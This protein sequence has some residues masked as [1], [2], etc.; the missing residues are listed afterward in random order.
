VSAERTLAS[1]AVD[2]TAS[3]SFITTDPS[4]AAELDPSMPEVERELVKRLKTGRAALPVLPRVAESAIRLA[5]DPDAR[6]TDLASLVDTDP[7]IA[8]RFLSVANSVI[9][10][11]GWVTSSTQSAI[12]RLGLAS[13]RDLLFQVVY[14][15]TSSGMKRYHGAVQASFRR[16]VVAAHASRIIARELALGSEYDYM[17]G[18][19]HDIGEARIYRILDGL[20][21]PADPAL[22][23]ALV[24]KYHES[25][26]AEV[27]MAWKLPTEIVDGCAAHHDLEAAATPHVRLVMIAD[28]VVL[29]IEAEADRRP[30]DFEAFERLL[31]DGGIARKLIEKTK[32]AVGPSL[33]NL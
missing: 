28:Q 11:R 4:L 20:K 1:S 8:A 13:T 30:I 15:A 12:V 31:V 9:Y 14:A 29:G 7:P 17:S 32:L 18:L 5:N 3:G 24:D 33:P 22:V 25:A 10:F 19:L 23:R 2:A 21:L 16:S 26:G 6:I 27:A